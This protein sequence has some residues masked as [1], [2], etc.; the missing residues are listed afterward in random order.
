[1]IFQSESSLQNKYYAS[2]APLLHPVFDY[3]HVS[4]ASNQDLPLVESPTTTGTLL[5][6]SLG[7]IAQSCLQCGSFGGRINATPVI[8]AEIGIIHEQWSIDIR[9]QTL[10]NILRNDIVHSLVEILIGLVD[11]GIID[12]Q[13]PGEIQL[14]EDIIVVGRD[15]EKILR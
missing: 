5:E 6:E 11:F 14:D 15:V 10:V 1:M 13:R 7:I 3:T 2:C 4:M 12:R 9:Q 8:L